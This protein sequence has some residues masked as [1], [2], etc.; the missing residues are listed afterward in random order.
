[1]IPP[2]RVL[3][4]P[5]LIL[6]GVG[7]MSRSANAQLMPKRTLAA[8]STLPC[9]AV[10]PNAV[11]SRNDSPDV[12]RL[13]SLGHEAAIV[14]DHRQ[15]R[16]VF[17]DA[18]R[19]SPGDERIAYQLG[20]AYEELGEKP[21]A[22]RE[23][24]RFLAL[25]PN[26]A[27][28]ADVRSRI[29]GLTASPNGAP[30]PG[31]QAANTFRLGVTHLDQRRWREAAEAFGRVIQTLPRA[32]EPYYDRA[33]AL[34]ALQERDA[35]VKDFEQ[36]LA[37]RPAAEDQPQ[38]RAQ[39]DALRRP[40]WS[41]TTA[42]VTGLV[43]PGLGQAYTSRPWMGLGVAAVAGGSLFLALQAKDEQEIRDYTVKIP[44]FPDIVNIDTVT[45]TKHPYYAGG[46]AA[47]TTLTIGAAFE[48]ARY[49]RKSQGTRR[50]VS[51][52]QPAA[53]VGS[54]EVYPPSVLPTRNGFGVAVAGQVSLPRF[55]R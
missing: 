52:R 54:L 14:G 11:A 33:I 32:P 45:V 47:F 38:V 3:V 8:T 19:L 25:A 36:Y 37:L 23:Y 20:R 27:D 4:L 1:M 31:D 9:P 43:L 29:T 46:L 53:R 7:A 40:T 41:T 26:A 42:L 51:P 21:N 10:V 22:I 49:A 17:V 2:I 18:A 39:I 5:A 12:R 48:A 50:P 34:S 35:A 28:A 30:T 55:V 44:G 15:A 6:A 16:D 24:C 13:M